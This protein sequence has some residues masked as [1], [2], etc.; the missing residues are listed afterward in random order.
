MPAAKQNRILLFQSFATYKDKRFCGF[1]TAIVEVIEHVDINRLPA[2]E[3]SVFKY[4]KQKTIVLTTPNREYNVQ[5]EYLTEGKLRH[6][7]HHF[8]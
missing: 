5:Y 2:F 6:P 3:T 1:D 8:E 7:D 4:A